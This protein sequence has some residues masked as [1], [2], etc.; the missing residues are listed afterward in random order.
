MN[1]VAYIL[2]PELREKLRRPLGILVCGSFTYTIRRLKEMIA[3]EK[4]PCIITVGDTVSRNAV[5]AGIYPRLL[6]V[7]NLAMRKR[8]Q[9]VETASE[10]LLIVSNPAGTVTEAAE[11]AV[12]KAVEKSGQAKLV[13]DGEEDL[14]ALIAIKCVSENS[15]VVYGQPREGIVVVKATAEK[16]REIAQIL[17]AMR[18]ARKV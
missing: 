6:I 15:F 14:L 13:V 18:Q 3:K 11:Q 12:C 17:D 2:T 1:S 16:K 9:P 5:Q 10:E 7:D 8:V 4:P